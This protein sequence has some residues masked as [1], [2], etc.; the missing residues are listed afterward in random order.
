MNFIVTWLSCE[1]FLTT[2]NKREL[3]NLQLLLYISESDTILFQNDIL[4]YIYVICK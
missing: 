2:L 3:L 1:L 4:R